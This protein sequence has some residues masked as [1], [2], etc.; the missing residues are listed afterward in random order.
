[1][2]CTMVDVYTVAYDDHVCINHIGVS[3]IKK[4]IH[5]LVLS[6][7]FFMDETMFIHKKGATQNQIVDAAGLQPIIGSSSEDFF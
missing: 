4:C 5:Y 1:M 7:P 6:G 3:C 2:N